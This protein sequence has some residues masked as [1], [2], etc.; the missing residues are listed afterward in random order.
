MSADNGYILRATEDGK[1]V[2]SYFQGDMEYAN[3]LIKFDTLEDAVR[4]YNRLDG[5]ESGDYLT[6]YRL[7]VDLR[8]ERKQSK[9]DILAAVHK[10]R[11]VKTVRVTEE[12]LE[13]VAQWCGGTV[14]TSDDGNNFVRVGYNPKVASTNGRLHRAYVGDWVVRIGSRH[15]RVYLDQAFRKNF[16]LPTE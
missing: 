3:N 6:E 13:E 14:D 15:F 12:N 16:K 8:N 9:M 7:T 1:Y 5:W 2:L 10:P 4:E 11:K